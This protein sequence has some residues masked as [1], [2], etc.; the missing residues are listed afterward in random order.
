MGLQVYGP[1]NL[2]KGVRELPG[3][4]ELGSTQKPEPTHDS[5]GLGF[6]EHLLNPLG[7]FVAF[8]GSTEI[9][10][11]QKARPMNPKL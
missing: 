7:N 6:R 2:G 8:A 11:V 4:P 1:G 3:S 9:L 10:Q 5:S